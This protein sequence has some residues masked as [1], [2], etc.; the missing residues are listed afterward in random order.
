[1]QQKEKILENQCRELA[2]LHGWLCLKLEKNG[3]K[4][5]PDDLFI[6]PKNNFFF[7]EFKKDDTQKLRPEQKTWK[8]RLGER[9]RLIS[10]ISEVKSLINSEE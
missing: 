4:G 1:M 3:H 2:R 8:A 9:F 10:S 6:S 7:V 5:V